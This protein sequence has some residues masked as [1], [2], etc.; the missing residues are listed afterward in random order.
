M[1]EQQTNKKVSN[2]RVVSGTV[3]SNKMDK[4]ITVKVERRVKHP[5]Y[6]KYIRR[7]TKL[8]AHDENNQCNVGDLVTIIECRPRSKTKTFEL[9][10]IDEAAAPEVGGDLAETEGAQ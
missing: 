3:V 4:S 8:H 5:I 6:G 7:S 9:R 10:S 1:T 2:P